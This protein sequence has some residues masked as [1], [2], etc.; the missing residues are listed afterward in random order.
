LNT[1]VGDRLLDAMRGAQID[2]ESEDTRVVFDIT[3]GSSR[4]LLE[5]LHALLCTDVNLTLTY[6]EVA[7]YRPSFDEFRDQLEEQ[8]VRRVEPPTG[9]FTRN[10]KNRTSSDRRKP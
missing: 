6:T 10:S 1:S 9:R 7:A 2:L 5:G 3:V 4:L 8:R